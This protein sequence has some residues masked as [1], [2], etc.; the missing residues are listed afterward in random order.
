MPRPTR[1]SVVAPIPG[2]PCPKCGGTDATLY[3]VPPPR[4][5]LVCPSCSPSWL[6]AWAAEWS[7]REAAYRP[8]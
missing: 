8:R 2:A 4:G 1:A 5:M 3:P 7:E 6:R